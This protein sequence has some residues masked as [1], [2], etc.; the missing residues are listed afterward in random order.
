MTAP[1]TDTAAD[2]S[3]PPPTPDTAPKPEPEKPAAT[4]TSSAPSAESSQ[5]VTTGNITNS[6]QTIN[7]TFAKEIKAYLLGDMIQGVSIFDWKSHYVF[8][9]EEEVDNARNF[10]YESDFVEASVSTLAQHRMLILHGEHGAG[11]ASMALYLAK[12][13]HESGDVGGRTLLYTPPQIGRASCR[14]RV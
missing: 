6:T 5:G 8:S 2:V 7:Q 14:E 9:R 1:A 4:S 13:L 10:A 12:R 3:Q 11:K